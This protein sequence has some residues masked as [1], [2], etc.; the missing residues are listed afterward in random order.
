[1]VNA[2][3]CIA[4]AVGIVGGLAGGTMLAHAQAAGQSIPYLN[5]DDLDGSPGSEPGSFRSDVPIGAGQT[6]PHRQ[7]GASQ[8]ELGG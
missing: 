6:W 5:K 7:T 8:Q 1:M 4:V 3:R 2:W